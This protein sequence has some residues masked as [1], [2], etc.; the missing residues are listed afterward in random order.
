MNRW[1]RPTQ[2]EMATPPPPQ[3]HDFLTNLKFCDVPKITSHG[4]INIPGSLFI[5]ISSK[6]KGG[7]DSAYKGLTIKNE[8]IQLYLHNMS[9]SSIT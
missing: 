6:V 5:F 3:N 9:Y 4:H 1:V 8:S 7:R 2:S